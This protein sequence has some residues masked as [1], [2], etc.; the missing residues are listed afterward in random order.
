MPEGL[1]PHAQHGAH[2]KTRLHGGALIRQE[3]RKSSMRRANCSLTRIF[4]YFKQ[5]FA[6]D[7]EMSPQ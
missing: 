6:S 7:K 2:K 4:N 5:R 1:P 3:A